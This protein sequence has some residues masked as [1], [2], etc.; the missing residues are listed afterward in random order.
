MAGAALAHAEFAELI[1]DLEHVHPGAIK[2]G[3]ESN[4]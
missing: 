1:P 2:N 4:T 3:I